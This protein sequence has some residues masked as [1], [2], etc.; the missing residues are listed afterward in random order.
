MDTTVAEFQRV[1]RESLKSLIRRHVKFGL[2]KSLSRATPE[3]IY[4]AVALS[5]REIALEKQFATQRKIEEQDPKVVFYLSMEFL[6]GRLLGNT[7]VNLGIDEPMAEA[8]RDLGFSLDDLKD[9]EIDAALGNGGLGRLAACFL[10]SLATLGY[11]GFGYGLYYEF[12][13]FRQEI[14]NGFQREKPDRWQQVIMPW[15]LERPEESVM[16][17]AY[18]RIVEGLDRHGR[19]NPMWLDWKVVIGTPHDIQVVGYGGKA[20]N[21]LRLYSAE[22]STD[23]DMQIFNSGDYIKAVEQKIQTETIS[24]VLY[25]ADAV[26]TGKELRLMQEYFFVACALNDIVKKFQKKHSDLTLFPQK[27]A[28]QLNDTHPTLAIPELMRI[29]IDEND[30]TWEKAWQITTE[31]F[32]YTNHTLLP[33]ALERWPVPLFEEI[34]PRHLQIIYEINRRF[35]D[36]AAVYSLSDPDFPRRVSIFEEGKTKEVRMANLAIVGSHSVNGVA[37]LHSELIKTSLVPDFHR[38]WPHKFNNKTNGVTPRRWLL[39]ANPSLASLLT[40]TIGDGWITDLD[41]LRQI[42]PKAEDAGFRSEFLKIKR[43]NKVRLAQVTKKLLRIN[44]DPDSMFDIQAKRI[45]EYKRQLLDILHVIHHYLSI[46]EFGVDFPVPKTYFFAGKAAPSYWTAKNIIKLINSVADRVNNDR[47]VRDRLKVVFLP[48]YRVT[49]AEVII[50]ACDLS[51]Q[52][53]TAGHE[54]SGTG[55]MKFAMNGALTIGTLDGANIEIA[56]AV[57]AGNIYI[58]GKTAQEIEEMNRQG[59]YRSWEAINACE[60]LRRVLDAVSSPL[61]SPGEPGIFD[62]VKKLLVDDGDRYFLAADFPS[63]ADSQIRA[64][65]DYQHREEWAKKAI[66]NVARMGPFSSDRTIKQYAEEI[67]GLKPLD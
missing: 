46:V 42:E 44:V 4:L 61:F 23:F 26:R 11:P 49:L 62:W 14:D 55:N 20:V 19:Y 9:L 12:G 38:L 64:A 34:V 33:E 65:V 18:G 50:P 30:F 59:S 60:P 57:G 36:E 3:D 45:H 37:A 1:D 63:Y 28:I 67:W 17:P 39:K 10:D 52:I 43:E 40:R 66:L 22:P 35:L 25:P 6:I 21:L 54:A 47:R 41:A 27:A 31:T 15:V 7:L 48:D 56:E 58:F 29:L 8:V 2:G 32:G 13:L 53:S 5:A 51:E 24:K 16:I